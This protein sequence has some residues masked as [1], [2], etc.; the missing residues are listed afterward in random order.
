MSDHMTDEEIRNNP[1]SCPYCGSDCA[2]WSD[3]LELE[4]CNT[5]E[6]TKICN[7]CDGVF[8]LIFKLQGWKK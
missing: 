3:D 8:V 5:V 1:E 6:V 2:T 7:D 4:D